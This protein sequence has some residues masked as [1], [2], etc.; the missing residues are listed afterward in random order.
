MCVCVCCVYVGMRLCMYGC[1]CDNI[2]FIFSTAQKYA[3]M[4]ELSKYMY[5]THK[6]YHAIH[7]FCSYSRP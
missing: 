4:H 2:V 5:V 1:M 3:R 6:V 7:V